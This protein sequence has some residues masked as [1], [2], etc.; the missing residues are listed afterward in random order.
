M[1]P[2]SC[3]TEGNNGLLKTSVEEGIKK[4]F[5]QQYHKRGIKPII[6]VGILLVDGEQ[7]HS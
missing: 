5:G 7:I 2:L 3:E 1:Y 4:T 6:W